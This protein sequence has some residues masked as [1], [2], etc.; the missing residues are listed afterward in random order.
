MHPDL[1][2]Q[3]A[4]IF[5]TYCAQVTA[6]LLL[7]LVLCR[8]SPAAERRFRVWLSFLLL[9][10]AWGLIQVLRVVLE[11]RNGTSAYSS[12]LLVPEFHG[13]YLWLVPQQWK[14]F[15]AVAAPL[16][17]LVYLTV[18]A[19]LI[20]MCVWRQVRL[21]LVLQ[22]GRAPGAELAELF[23]TI[24]RQSGAGN[25]DLTVVPGVVSP[26]TAFWWRPRIILPEVCE[27]MGADGAMTALL[28][29]ELTHVR[30]RDYLWALAGDAVCCVLFFH[31]AVWKARRRMRI[32]RE[33]AC[34]RAVVA[35]HPGERANYAE[36]LTR[37]SRLLLIEQPAET[38]IDFARN[39]SLLSERVHAILADNR[40]EPGWQTV[41][42][43]LGSGAAMAVFC[44]L[45]PALAVMLQFAPLSA[46]TTAGR[47]PSAGPEL[48]RR[49][50]LRHPAGGADRRF[51]SSSAMMPIQETSATRLAP[52]WRG[53][54]LPGPSDSA[55]GGADGLTD[56]SPA[57]QAGEGGWVEN[58]S[59]KSPGSVK[60]V[61][62]G[63]AAVIFG[64]HEDRTD[65]PARRRLPGR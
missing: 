23:E 26:A 62:L 46:E 6:G 7:C 17:L 35:K 12:A 44:I 65:H 40:R 39:I 49:A 55:S 20:G 45:L 24:R 27:E 36:L 2:L 3:F 11:V 37:F 5:L 61:L 60:G 50:H 34:D 19:V 28:W 43:A 31:P 16:T 21:H 9:S 48:S 59:A 8:L 33:L 58:P 53:S 10:G 15:L 47:T 25:C 54:A 38:G 4:G 41:A 30:R 22:Y 56:L 29:H 14:P 64:G 18:V 52:R 13:S 42:R 1:Y 51:N 57:G 32:D 63:T